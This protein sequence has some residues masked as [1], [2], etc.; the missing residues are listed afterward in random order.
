MYVNREELETLRAIEEKIDEA[1]NIIDACI[2][3]SIIVGHDLRGEF[4]EFA[5]D[6]QTLSKKAAKLSSVYEEKL[7][8]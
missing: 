5:Y 3:K 6:L 7:N 4:K 1:W 2:P 8:K